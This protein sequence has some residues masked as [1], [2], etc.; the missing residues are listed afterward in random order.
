MNSKTNRYKNVQQLTI[1]NGEG[2]KMGQLIQ[3]I[4]TIVNI[5]T[6]TPLYFIITLNSTTLTT[7]TYCIM[8]YLIDTLC[9]SEKQLQF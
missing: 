2:P 6:N 9:N 1:M 3:L 8:L 5:L 4:V 7:S